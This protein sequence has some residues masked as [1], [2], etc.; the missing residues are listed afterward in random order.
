[1]SAGPEGR[2][3]RPHRTG[4]MRW[5]LQKACTFPISLQTGFAAHAKTLPVRFINA[6]GDL[7][8]NSEKDSGLYL[9]EGG[10]SK[11]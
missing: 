3:L 9:W 1:M 4:Y 11:H 5:V 7:I 10:L 8:C 6:S 2:R